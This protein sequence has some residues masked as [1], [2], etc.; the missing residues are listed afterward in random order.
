MAMTKMLLGFPFDFDNIDLNKINANKNIF[1]NKFPEESLFTKSFMTSGSKR[2]YSF[3]TV[4]YKK[5]LKKIENETFYKHEKFVPKNIDS[6]QT[7]RENARRFCKINSEYSFKPL[8]DFGF[9]PIDIVPFLSV[10]D[11]EPFIDSVINSKDQNECFELLTKIRGVSKSFLAY[12]IFVDLSYIPE[13]KFS[14][15]EFTIAGPGCE[16]GLDSLFLNPD[17]MNYEEMLFW[18][19]DNIEEEYKK[20]NLIYNPQELYYFLPDYDRCLNIQ[21]I[22]NSFCELS[23]IIKIQ[24]GIGKRYTY[25][26]KVQVSSTLE[27][28]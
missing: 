4:V 7:Y 13:F 15:N 18:V 26:E 6:F 3:R 22:E 27:D 19:R 28:F 10:I 2:A 23:K 17:G 8:S 25:K 16:R 21:M 20:L 11:F 9:D 24:K 5:D 14:E 12:Q 1:K